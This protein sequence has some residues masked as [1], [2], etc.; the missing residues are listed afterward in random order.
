MNRLLTAMVVGGGCWGG[1]TMK[2]VFVGGGFFFSSFL[3][4][5]VNLNLNLNKDKL[6]NRGSVKRACER[7]QFKLKFKF[8]LI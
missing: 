4:L 8:K 5:V 3:T 1:E 2:K 6:A 7:N